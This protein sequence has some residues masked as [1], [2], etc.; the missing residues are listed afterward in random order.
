M[1]VLYATVHAAE[2]M[3]EE[4]AHKFVMLKVMGGSNAEEKCC[5]EIAE[6]MISRPEDQD[7]NRC[8]QILPRAPSLQTQ[9]CEALRATPGAI[10]AA[11]SKRL[12]FVAD[13]SDSCC[14]IQLK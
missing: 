10:N 1:R 9:M 3:Y 6:H 14:V 2:L 12:S 4:M 5:E 13:S 11:I 7:A 8:Q